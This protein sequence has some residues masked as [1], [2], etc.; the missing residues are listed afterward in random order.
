[1]PFIEDSDDLTVKELMVHLQ[2]RLLRKTH[3][4]GVVTFQ[5]VIDFWTYQEIIFETQP[6]V[7]IEIGNFAGG[8]ALALA[9]ILDN[10]GNGQVI[11]ID[12]SHEFLSPVAK[13]HPRIEFLRGDACELYQDVVN[14]I[15]DGARVMIIEDSSHTY[16]NTLNILN[17][18]AALVSKGCYFI[19]EDT[20]CDHGLESEPH[21]PNA[22]EAV[23]AFVAENRDYEIDRERESFILTWNPKGY[24]KRVN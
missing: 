11:G 9:H 2:E 6:D 13:A 24:L 14:K 3:Y 8:S 5:S 22:F 7:I 15:P 16:E 4:F 23:E 20:V 21:A 17:T 18:Y 12:I 19:I 1:M 10:I